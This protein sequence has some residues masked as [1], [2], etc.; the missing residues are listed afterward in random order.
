MLYCSVDYDS[1]ELKTW[2]QVC[3]WTVGHSRLAQVLNGGRCPHTELGA[4]LAH[5]TPEAAYKARKEPGNT[6]DG[7]YRQTAKIANF[8]YPGGMGPATLKIQARKE[9]KVK[10][11]LEECY[12]LRDAWRA[13]WP[14]AKD[15]F[16]WVNRQLRGPRDRQK[17]HAYHFQTGRIRGNIPYTVY[18]NTLFQGLAADAAKA[19]GFKV[20]KEM[21]AAPSSPLYGSRIVNFIHDEIL[22]EVPEQPELAHAAAFRLRDI[23]VEEAQKLIPDIR[24]TAEPALMRR[25]YKGAKTVYSPSG[26]LMPW[27]P[28]ANA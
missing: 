15:Y 28:P 26:L 13:E 20:A 14:E 16:D 23:M 17:G 22:A 11:T 6:F 19:A 10:L 3:L 1:F 18:C 2:A 4:R 8:G 5:I 7:T 9:Y 27:E 25:W 12:S 24:I 21:Y